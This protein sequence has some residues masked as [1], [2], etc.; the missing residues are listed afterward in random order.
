MSASPEHGLDLSGDWTGIYSYP[1]A[2]PPVSFTASLSEQGGWISGV[3]EEKSRKG[4]GLARRLGATI[5]GR[6]TGESVTWLK[7]YDD[8]DDNYDAVQYEG[9]ISADGEE[10]SGCWSIFGDWSGSFLMV[11]KSRAEAGSAG[12]AASSTGSRSGATRTT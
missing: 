11:R 6:R 7:L 8:L 4:V 3:V 2:I 5:Q 12:V 1:R 10:I 9:A